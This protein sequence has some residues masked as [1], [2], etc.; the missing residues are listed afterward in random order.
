MRLELGKFFGLECY[1]PPGVSASETQAKR[2]AVLEIMRPKPSPFGFMRIGGVDD[3]AYLVPSDLDNVRVCFSPGVNNR[4]N[5]EDQLTIE[6]D[7]T[8]HMCDYSSDQFN[9]STPLISGKQTFDKLWLEPREGGNCID[10]K[11]W[12]GKYYPAGRRDLM[13]QMDIEGAEYRNILAADAETL[14]RFR[15]IVIEVHGLKALS[16]PDVVHSVLY[17]FFVAIGNL[18]TSIHIHPN[19]YSEAISLEPEN[20]RISDVV[21]LT[22]VRNDVFIE[23]KLSSYLRDVLIPHPLDIVNKADGEP[24]ALGEYWC[25]GNRP[26]SSRVKII[27]DD[28]AFQKY[29]H[30]Q[31]FDLINEQIVGAFQAALAGSVLE[32]ECMSDSEIEAENTLAPLQDVA[33][34]RPFELS[35]GEPRVGR[36]VANPRDFFFHTDLGVN[37]S[38]TVDLEDVRSISAIVIVNRL[39]TCFERAGVLSLSV[40]SEITPQRTDQEYYIRV[41]KE[42][43]T[44]RKRH[45]IVSVL[46]LGA[47]YVRLTA[48]TYTWFHLADLRIY[49]GRTRS[50]P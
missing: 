32:C 47:R 22:F 26:I 38:I 21:E 33:S 4:K 5:F 11:S 8:C 16:R 39:D 50:T 15:I 34:G 43:L 23:K 27:E 1:P 24:I 37:E 36:V 10:L 28:L 49:A 9:L 3:G 35:S 20:I 46:S 6:H 2:T 31:R 40:G 25:G 17:D 48:K 13:L 18:F 19:N 14:G 12:V 42:F 30:R 29:L 45:V 7:I 41:P 44:G